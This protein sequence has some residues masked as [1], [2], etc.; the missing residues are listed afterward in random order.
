[1]TVPALRAKTPASARWEIAASVRVH[2]FLSIREDLW[3]DQMSAIMVSR[4]RV[5]A[6]RVRSIVL[7]ANGVDGVVVSFGPPNSP[8]L[9]AGSA[10]TDTTY[11]DCRGCSLMPCFWEVFRSCK[12]NQ[13]EINA[14][15][16]RDALV[17]TF[18]WIFHLLRLRVATMNSNNNRNGTCKNV[19]PPTSEAQKVG[20]LFKAVEPI[21]VRYSFMFGQVSDL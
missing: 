9:L 19:Y 15:V 21:K 16:A 3:R 11:W 10:P 2:S 20:N 12:L 4:R 7:P 13:A 1:M 17:A 6:K 8:G 14:A 18:V 5:T